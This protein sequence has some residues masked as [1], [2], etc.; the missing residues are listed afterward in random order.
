MSSYITILI[1]GIQGEGVAST[2]INLMK[3][4]SEL[5]YY[6]YGERKFSSTIKGANTHIA[7]TISNEPVHS[8]EYAYDIVM[9][10]DEETLILNRASLKTQ[11]IILVDE[12]VKLTQKIDQTE[13]MMVLPMTS[14]A[15]E[16]GTALMK[17]TCAI[18]FI[19]RMLQLDPEALEESIAST[20]AKREDS[21]IQQ[22]I[23]VLRAAYSYEASS[24]PKLTLLPVKAKSEAPLVLMT[25]NDALALGAL[26][27]GCRFVAAYP[28]TPASDIME[29]MGRELPAEGGLMIQTEDEIAAVIM[30][31][32]AAYAGVR[33]MTATSG[34][35]LSLMIE[36]LGLAG[37]TETPLVLVDAQRAGPSTGMPTRTEQSDISFLY[38]AGHGEYPL[39]MLTP[40]TIEESYQ[41]TINAFNLADQYQCPVII[42]MDLNLSLS[43]QTIP[44]PAYQKTQINRGLMADLEELLQYEENDKTYPRYQLT[45]S[46]I[47]ARTFPGMAGGMHQATGLEHS[48]VGLPTDQPVNRV[49]MM[50]K[51]LR[52]TKPLEDQNAVHVVQ[53][54]GYILCLTFGS[55]WGVL[56]EAIKDTNLP[57]DSAH[58]SRIR[59]L[60]VRQLR[61]LFGGYRQVIVMEHNH[62]GQLA[63]ILKHEIGFSEKIT[64]LNRYDG[65]SFKTNEV[66]AALERWCEEWK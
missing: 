38:Y 13:R 24:L 7:I 33:S 46:G 50:D 52:K 1:G 54:D 20:Y 39:I 11:G 16:H 15:K 57:V 44:L 22:N 23:S 25:G 35:G 56:Q 51:R 42:L 66:Y 62:N 59:P 64:S 21:I 12:S 37:M 19:G 32:G 47:S 10:F 6:T 58:I 34:P 2:G 31:T 41:L 36:G 17:N 45:D 53:N 49:L 26:M 18:G 65:Q 8:C 28:I 27:G 14:L 48:L 5:H 43:P 61:Q 9:A 30:C 60:P 29:L 63:G 3:A 40:S 55:P 4:L